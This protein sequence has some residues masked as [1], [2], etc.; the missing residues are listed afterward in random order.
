MILDVSLV[1]FAADV[2]AKRV[3]VL[4][5]GDERPKFNS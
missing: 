4:E 2:A 3:D 5:V 1:L